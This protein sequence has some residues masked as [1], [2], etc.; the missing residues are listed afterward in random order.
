NKEIRIFGDRVIMMEEG[1]VTVGN[2][3]FIGKNFTLPYDEF[4]LTM[5]TIDTVLFAVQDPKNPNIKYDLGGEIKMNAG[6]LLINHPNNKS[7]L[8]KGQIPGWKKGEIY[9]SF[10][11]LKVETGGKIYFDAF[12]RERFA[13]H[14]SQA[15]FE[16]PNIELDSLTSKTPKFSGTFYSNIFPPIKEELVAI[17]DPKYNGVESKYALGFVHRPKK[18]LKLYQTK[19]ELKADSIVMYK[20][21]LVASGKNLEIKNHTY[22]LKAESVVLTP[23]SVHTKKAN[24]LVKQGKSGNTAYPEALGENLKLSWYTTKLVGS[25]TLKIDSLTLKN[26]AKDFIRIFD[27]KNPASLSGTMAITPNA[28]WAIGKFTRKDFFLFAPQGAIITPDRIFTPDLPDNIVEFKVHSTDLDPFNVDYGTDYKHIVDANAIFVDFDLKKS[29][30]KISHNPLISQQSP[31]YEFFSFPYAQ[32]K[33][34]IKEAIWDV[35]K[36]EITMKGDENTIFH[37]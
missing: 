8:K 3:R 35:K 6:D 7:G 22:T 1:E 32:F 16:I 23:D 29:I 34:S 26:S 9:E 27:D 28:L 18:P 20:T 31:Q 17:Y 15:Y 14:K 21:G 2:F 36:K 25:D 11:K 13:Y 24:I 5:E 12:Y 33:T 4:K 37:A 30:C 19:A 10:P